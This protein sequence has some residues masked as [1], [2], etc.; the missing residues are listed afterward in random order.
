M[1]V[2]INIKMLLCKMMIER[3]RED[4]WNIFLKI[5]SDVIYEFELIM[6]QSFLQPIGCDMMVG[7]T[8]ENDQCGVCKGD[9]STCRIIQ[10]EYT[11][12]PNHD[13]KNNLNV[14]IVNLRILRYQMN[15]ELIVLHLCLM[16]RKGNVYVICYIAYFREHIHNFF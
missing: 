16:L 9:N 5:L 11:E 1:Y 2:N 10:G 12:Q 7:S 13:S 15:I 3:E 8:A 6:H 14:I 4:R